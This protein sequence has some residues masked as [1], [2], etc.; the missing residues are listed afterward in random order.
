M[1]MLII[2][3]NPNVILKNTGT[4]TRLIKLFK[5]FSLRCEMDFFGPKPDNNDKVHHITNNDNAIYTHHFNQWS[6]GGKYLAIFTD[7]NLSFLST[8]KKIIKRND[9]NLIFITLPYGV[10]LCSYIC[11]NIPII[12]DAEFVIKGTSSRLFADELEK[13]FPRIFQYFP[14]SKIIGSIIMKYLTLLEQL[15]CNKA[16]QIVTISEVDK[17]RL[18]RLY[19]VH[20]DKITV[21]PYYMNSNELTEVLCVKGKTKSR[22]V[23]VV[24]H[25]SCLDHPANYEAF[26]LLINYIAPETEKF[27]TNIRFLIAG[28]NVP[29]FERRNIKSLGFVKDINKFLQEADIAIVPFLNGSGVKIKIFDYMAAGI[30]I[31]TSKNGIEG[32]DA[33]DGKHAIIVDT[34]DKEFINAILVLA[35]DREKRKLLRENALEL[36]KANYSLKMAQIKMED[37]LD[38]INERSLN[39]TYF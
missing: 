38:K 8:L 20:G 4:R 35:K 33:E 19:N 22:D 28:T 11:R 30:P 18:I 7:I 2:Y 32:I 14:I 12:Y 17:Q 31:I 6:I 13:K 23:V 10:I 1:K 39:E 16:D 37:M 36:I 34:V 26:K 5:L 15:A 24:F 29:V 9:V 3:T 21:I 27:N 25:G